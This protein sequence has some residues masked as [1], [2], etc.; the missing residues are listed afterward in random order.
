[1]RT[2]DST[3]GVRILDSQSTASLLSKV[4][5]ITTAGFL[6]TAV[7]AYM[8]P[9]LMGG[10]SFFALV[11]LNFGL[12]FAISYASKRSPGLALG[13]F[14][15][16]TI[17][18]GVEIGPLLKAYLHFPGGEMV[19]F[20]AA[21]TTALGMF[22]MGMIAQIVHFDYRKVYNYA[23]GALMALIVVGV[24]GM[25]VHFLSPGIY[26]W[27][28]LAIFSVLLLVDFMRLRDGAQGLS[29]VQMALSIYLDALNIFIALLQIF[30]SS[31]GNGGG[32]SSSR[33]S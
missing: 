6:F 8:A 24:I 22:A 27:A 21:L 32:R 26:A 7:G 1:M 25:F 29:P 15:L 28:T 3:Q 5:W 16:F 30:G 10:I 13:L 14:Y 17:L 20:D 19:V 4:L 18:M 9:A 11:I 33:W 12:I 2:I 23:L 31:N